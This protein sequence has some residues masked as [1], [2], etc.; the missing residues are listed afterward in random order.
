VKDPGGGELFL[1]GGLASMLECC[2]DLQEMVMMV[3]FV[4]K[5][6]ARRIRRF[7]FWI[8]KAEIRDVKGDSDSDKQI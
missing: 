5:R 2:A 1:Y 6:K 4:V 3:V 7:N 8:V